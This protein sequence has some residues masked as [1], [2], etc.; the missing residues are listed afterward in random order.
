MSSAD[1]A[2]RPVAAAPP[3][4]YRGTLGR[5]VRSELGLVFGRR[6]N[7]AMLVVLSAIPILIG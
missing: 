5:Q 7:I 2:V 4:A 3:T 1:L 6:R